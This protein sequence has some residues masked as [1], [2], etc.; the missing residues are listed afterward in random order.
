MCTLPVDGGLPLT[1]TRI[2]SS[3]GDAVAW[4]IDLAS[5]R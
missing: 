2:G 4:F 5:G 3:R 1:G